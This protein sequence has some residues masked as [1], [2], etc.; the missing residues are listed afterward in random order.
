[1]IGTAMTIAQR[2]EFS[3]SQNNGIM[4]LGNVLNVKPLILNDKRPREKHYDPHILP[5]AS[6]SVAVYPAASFDRH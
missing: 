3:R 5:P 6:V 4:E 2:R 1:V